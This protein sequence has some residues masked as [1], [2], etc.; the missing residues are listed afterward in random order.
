AALSIN[1]GQPAGPVAVTVSPGDQTI[2]LLDNG[3]A[4]DQA[5]GDG[6]Y[7]G[8]WTPPGLGNYTLTFSNAEAVQA[9]VL[10][11]YSVGETSFTYQ[12]IT[13][14]KLTLG[15]DDVATIISPF[16]V[17]FGGG[18]F[19]TVYVSSNGTLSFTNA[20]D[21]FINWYLPLNYLGLVNSMNGPPPALE[22]PVVT[23]V[24]PFWE[25]LYPVK[26]TDQ[27]VFW[28]ITGST[29][30]RQLVIEWRNVRTYECQTDEN[31]TVTFQ[32]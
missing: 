19:T 29:P 30:N 23:L 26:G 2:T 9:T 20:F 10:N 4:P 28:Q 5:S 18:A 6:I 16:P 32:V 8:Q 14:T 12:T 21:D 7:T 3:V 1:C 15:D 17:P 13:G 27:N 31:A 25:D 22:L 11:N 24:A